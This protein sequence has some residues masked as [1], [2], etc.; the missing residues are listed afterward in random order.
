MKEKGS[1]R[2]SA[3]VLATVGFLTA[4]VLAL[5]VLFDP[6]SLL[7]SLLSRSSIRRE[8]PAA[9]ALWTSSGIE[10]YT[11]DVQGY[12]PLVCIFNATLTVEGGQLMGVVQQDVLGG[13]DREGSPVKPEDWDNTYCSFQ[14]L[15]V[16]AVFNRVEDALAGVNRSGDSLKVSF[17]PEY[18]FV[19]AY[20]LAPCCQG[21]ILSPTCTD[22]AIWFRFSNFQPGG[23]H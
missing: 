7:G 8:L 21:G 11:I 16:P 13:A 23:K 6:L 22:C 9:R 15:L 3:V 4:A 10:D 20:S 17:D 18:G 5:Q 1:R 2:R 14:E 12:V 19:T